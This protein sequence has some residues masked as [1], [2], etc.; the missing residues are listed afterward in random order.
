MKFKNFFLNTFQDNPEKIFINYMVNDLPTG[1]I[2]NKFMEDIHY[3]TILEQLLKIYVTIFFFF[4][5][6]IFLN[7]V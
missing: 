2:I 1:D 5:K 3:W 7:S 4:K 6:I